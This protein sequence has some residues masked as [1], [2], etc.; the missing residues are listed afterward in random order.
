MDIISQHTASTVPGAVIAAASIQAHFDVH[1]NM[2]TEAFW[3]L[4]HLIWSS[5]LKINQIVMS[6]W[7]IN[8]FLRKAYESMYLQYF[9]Q[10]IILGLNIFWEKIY[11][12]HRMS[13]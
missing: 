3:I 6:V 4:P 1:L 11:A 13:A 12:L 10:E 9:S 8:R 7:K 2:L 5:I